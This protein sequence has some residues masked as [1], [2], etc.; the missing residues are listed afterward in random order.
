MADPIFKVTHTP[1]VQFGPELN[2]RWHLT[3]VAH[4][5]NGVF[6]ASKKPAN[7]LY[8]DQYVI[9]IHSVSPTDLCSDMVK[10]LIMRPIVQGGILSFFR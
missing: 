2:W 8:I 5:P 4:I 3:T 6:V 1:A 9:L 7:T 10:M